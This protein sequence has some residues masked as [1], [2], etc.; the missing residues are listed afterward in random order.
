MGVSFSTRIWS[1]PFLV[2]DGTHGEAERLIERLDRLGYRRT[3]NA[4]AKGQYRWAPPELT[5]YLRGHSIPGSSQRE[6][7]YFLR[8][9][10]SGAWSVFDGLGDPIPEIRL[11]PE[12]VAELA[13][14]RAERREPA[15]WEQLPQSLKDAV[16]ATE[17]KRFWHHHGLDP[18]AMTRAT[19]G[20]MRGS[21]LQGASTITQQLAKNLFLSPHRTLRRKISE[22]ALSLYL[23]MRLDKKRILTLYLNHIYLGQDGH[24]SVM[25]VRSAARHYFSKEVSDLTLPESALIAGVIRGPGVYNPFRDPAT[26]KARRNHVLRRMRTEN[27][28][29]Q[30]EL[31]A[32]LAAPLTLARASDP[33]DRRDSAYYSAEVVRQLLPRYGGDSLYRHG[34]SIHTAMDPL[35]QNLA[36]KTLASAKHQAALVVLDPR[37]GSILALTGGR[38]FTESQFNRATQAQRQP[39]STFKP[40]VYAAAL[41]LGLTPATILRDKPKTYPDAGKGWSPANYAGVYLGTTTMRLALTHSL[42]SATLDLAER[43]GLKRIQE[44]ARACGITSPMR[45]DLGLALGASEVDLLEIVAA[46]TPFAHGGIRPT[47]RLITSVVDSDGVVLEA[48][49]PEAAVAFDPA[50][51]FLMNSMLEDVTKTGTARGL[52][53]M[54]VSFPAAG[55]TGTTND[56]RDAWFIGYTSSL[57]AGV[58]VGDDQNRPLRLTGSKD[59]LPLWAAFMKEASA[60]RPGEPFTR[61]DSVLEVVVCPS[62]G[63]VARSGCPG[64]HSEYFLA[65]TE[66]RSECALHRGGL[67]GWL[68]RLLRGN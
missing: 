52:K 47:P 35:L 33:E 10:G 32:A 29:A 60:D 15:S 48:P 39:G 46:Y 2:K 59:A 25:G 49:P 26:A 9:S 22:A 50:T 30:F 19:L 66:P 42:N 57:L 61:P 41:Q 53:H 67:A 37:D 23:E 54:G 44:T 38:S 65:G 6:G 45:D 7:A 51:A 28:I 58:W 12:L 63:M 11:E 56:G 68:Q 20:N 55:K 4:P 1:A 40:F 18:R 31:E 17:D 24:A 27:M 64:K 62:S 14:T 21:K 13:G 8:R 16:V 5:V 34:L 3:Q 43:V 36:R